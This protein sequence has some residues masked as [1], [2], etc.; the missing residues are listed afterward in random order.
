MYYIK[1][2]VIII[3]LIPIQNLIANESSLL[4]SI[5]NEFRKQENV[6]RDIYRKPL[7]TLNFFGIKSHFNVLEILPGKGYYSEILSNY[8]DKNGNYFAASFGDDHPVEYLKKLHLN[9]VDY[10]GDNKHFGKVNVIKF[11]NKDYLEQIEMN[12]LDMILTFRNSH[13]WLYN[14]QINDIYNTFYEKLKKNGILGVVQHRA[15]EHNLKKKNGYVDEN[16]L[17]NLIESNGFKLIGKSEINS[18]PRDLKNHPKGVWTLPPTLR[19]GQESKEKYLEIGE[20]D[21]MTLKFK[22][23]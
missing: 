16:F 23:L 12:S 21:R 19:L 6:K 10:F 4:L 9:Y 13:N 11:K 18:N 20:S 2:L 5:N 8:L 1:I 7:E 3:F 17:I 14:N 15:N 22:K